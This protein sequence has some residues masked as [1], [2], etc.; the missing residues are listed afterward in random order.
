AGLMMIG[1]AGSLDLNGA[2]M[3][4]LHTKSKHDLNVRAAFVHM[5]GD[6]IGAVGIIAGAI[7][8]R[9]TGW[10]QIDPVLSIVIGVLIVWTA[11]D[12]VKESLNILLEGL[13]TGL[14]LTSVTDAMRRVE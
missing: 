9:F 2:I 4:S 7:A 13:P 8:I 12:I 6:A 1:T 14:E 10:Q 5:M 11:W 3:W